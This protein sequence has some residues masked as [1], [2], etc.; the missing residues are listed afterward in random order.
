MTV[1]QFNEALKTLELTCN[2]SETGFPASA[3]QLVELIES[4]PYADCALDHAMIRTLYSSAN[5]SLFPPFTVAKALDAKLQIQIDETNMRVTALLTTAQ[6]GAMCTLERLQLALSDAG[7]IKGHRTAK[8]ESFL[9]KQFELMPG[10][11]TS[12]IVALGQQAK[13]GQDARFVKLCQTAQDRVLAPQARGDGK[14]DMRDLGAI[15]TVEPG[16]PLMERIPATKGTHGYS[17]FGDVIEAKP[18]VDHQMQVPEGTKLDP[19]NPNILLADSVGV[20]VSIPRGIRI[21][22]V[23]CYQN[24]DVTTGHIEFDGSVIVNGDV[25]E[26]MRIKATG[27]ITIMGVAESCE[28]ESQSCITVKNGIIGRKLQEGDKITCVVKAKGNIAANFAQYSHL[29][30]EQDILIERQVLHC[31]LFSQRLIK[32][33]KGDK[34]N[35]KI[36]G[37]QIL[38]AIRV[39]AGEIGAPSGTKTKV[40]VGQY[41]YELKKKQEHISDLEKALMAKAVSLANAKANAAKIA[42]SDKKQAYLAKIQQSDNH[43]STKLKQL[44]HNKSILSKKIS[45][46][47]NSSR[48]LVNDLAYSGVELKLI[49]EKEQVTRNYPPHIIMLQEG[50]LTRRYP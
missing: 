27:D 9:A 4:S 23:L 14:V 48:I 26:G 15:I 49:N 42:C 38:N 24:V 25:Q 10:E 50:K 5:K 39:E 46:L 35:G 29:Q 43:I 3:S 12:E 17:V 30:S 41:F 6:G 22:D 44:L 11:Q 47:L 2:P 20:P 18:G 34:A 36:V 16:A 37:G 21:D 13:N 19:T 1:L 33:G 45:M 7:V 8:F 32:V 28:L 31:D 40:H